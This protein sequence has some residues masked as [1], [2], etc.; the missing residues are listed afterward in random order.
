MFE[1]GV[2]ARSARISLSSFTYSYCVTV[3][4]SPASFAPLPVV[5]E[6]GLPLAL[7]G[8]IP[9]GGTYSGS[10]IANGIFNPNIA[11][12]GTHTIEYN[13]VSPTGCTGNAFQDIQV[14]EE[15]WAGTDGSSVL[16]TGDGPVDLFTL[17]GGNPQS[18]GIWKDPS[19]NVISSSVIDPLICL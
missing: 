5:C 15:P 9:I 11:G 13:Y 8:G 17:L 18:N 3:G 7:S 12:V 10:G 16:C 6:N 2:R 19:G 1:R 14:I 4:N